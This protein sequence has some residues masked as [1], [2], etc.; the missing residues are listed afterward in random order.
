MEVV[1]VGGMNEGGTGNDSSSRGSSAIFFDM[2]DHRRL[3]G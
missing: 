1:G 2:I 3:K